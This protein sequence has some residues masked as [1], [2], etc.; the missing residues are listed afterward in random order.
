LK[1]VNR[2]KLRRVCTFCSKNLKAH[3]H[4]AG[5][6]VDVPSKTPSRQVY[7][8]V[9]KERGYFK[10]WTARVHPYM[11][12]FLLQEEKRLLNFLNLPLSL[13][14]LTMPLIFSR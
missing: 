6:G 4:K 2:A 10:V 7:L 1:A 12:Y 5:L 11:R 8:Q 13:Y 3:V 9:E 14:P